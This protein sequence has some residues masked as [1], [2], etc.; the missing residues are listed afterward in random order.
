MTS[1]ATRQSPANRSRIPCCWRGVSRQDL[2][3]KILRALYRGSVARPRRWRSS[4]PVRLRHSSRASPARCTTW[5]GIHD[6]PRAGEFFGGGA[7]KAGESI[8]RD[9]LNALAP[10]VR[11]GGQPGCED[12]LGSARDH[13]QEPGGTAAIEDG[14]HVQDDGDVPVPIRGV[15]LHVFINAYDAHPLETIGIVDEYALAF[16]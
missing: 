10:S 12:P 4:C 11:L 6:H 13:I 14:R 1:R 9:D 8:H 3:C 2:V 7:L 16:T 5:K 15:T